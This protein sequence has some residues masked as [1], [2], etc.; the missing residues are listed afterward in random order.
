MGD[1]E[2]LQPSHDPHPYASSKKTAL[3]AQYRRG[4]EDNRAASAA[5]VSAIIRAIIPS[6]NRNLLA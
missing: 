3:W 6:L 4:G 2:G 1:Q 5:A